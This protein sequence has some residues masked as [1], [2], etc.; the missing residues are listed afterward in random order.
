[1]KL[2][3]AIALIASVVATAGCTQTDC[4]AAAEDAHAVFLAEVEADPTAF[5]P[6]DL[7]NERLAFAAAKAACLALG[8]AVVK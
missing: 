1:M 6:A 3:F 2:V 8:R 7:R 5:S 4:V